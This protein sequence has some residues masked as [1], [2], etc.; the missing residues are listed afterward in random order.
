MSYFQVAEP[1]RKDEENSWVLTLGKADL[2][3]NAPSHYEVC[4]NLKSQGAQSCIVNRTMERVRDLDSP[5]EEAKSLVDWQ[6][7]VAAAQDKSQVI[8]GSTR[9]ELEM[10]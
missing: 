3:L 8:P 2:Q 5:G 7:E 10:V 4:I 6:E 9:T 1:T